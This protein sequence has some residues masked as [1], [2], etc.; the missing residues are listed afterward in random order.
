MQIRHGF[1]A[2]F[3]NFTQRVAHGVVQCDSGVFGDFHGR[4]SGEMESEGL[5]Y[6]EKPHAFTKMVQKTRR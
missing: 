4:E 3:E 5:D 6:L 1:L 2:L